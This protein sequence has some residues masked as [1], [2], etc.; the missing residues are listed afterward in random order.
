MQ[1]ESMQLFRE[2]NDLW[3]LAFALAQGGNIL[4]W[5]GA[6]PQAREHF[7]ESIDLFQ[8]LGDR[9]TVSIPFRGLGMLC[10]IE[11]DN[12]TAWYYLQ[13][14]LKIALELNDQP[15]IGWAFAKLAN[16]AVGQGDYAQATQLYERSLTLLKI[17]G[18]ES[19][20]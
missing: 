13:E 5:T 7:Q 17:A 9:W 19:V 18:M 2:A 4:D 10:F 20:V 8:E 12:P 16:V 3:W 11:R 15:G 1:Q 6:Y 14:Y